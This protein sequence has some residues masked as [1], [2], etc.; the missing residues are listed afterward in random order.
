MPIHPIG[1]EGKKGSLGC[2]YANRDYRAVNPAYGTMADFRE[3]ADAI[4]A[5]GMKVM[6]SNTAQT[7][8]PARVSL[9]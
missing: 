8:F 2:P 1:V 7:S 4:H 5:R 6:K 9:I 3:L